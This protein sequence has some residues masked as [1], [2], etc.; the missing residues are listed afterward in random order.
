MLSKLVLK[1]F[2]PGSVFPVSFAWRNAPSVSA[3]VFSSAN[4]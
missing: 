4:A 2:H 3:F 1:P